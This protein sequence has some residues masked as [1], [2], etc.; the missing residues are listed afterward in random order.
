M[1]NNDL[2]SNNWN[3]CDDKLPCRVGGHQMNLLHNK[4]ILTGGQIN[5]SLS[6]KV[7]QGI[8]S[9]N[10]QLRV[11]WSPL[12]PMMETRHRHVAVVIQ[13]KLFCIGGD[14]S[15][16]S[17]YFCLETNRWQKGPEL[18]FTL[19]GAK[20]VLTNQQ[21]K[22]YLLGGYRDGKISENI[23]L[24]DPIKGVERIKGCLDIPLAFHIAVLL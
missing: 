22:C 11:N 3:V 13:D 5:Y 18:P 12:P 9:F 21:N 19:H 16:S 24:F 6:N 23:T 8:I 4:V 1:I 7:W 2:Q 20:A 10:Q 15:K 14:G 17:E